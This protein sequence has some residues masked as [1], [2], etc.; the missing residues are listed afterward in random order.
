MF[1]STADD[2]IVNA[3]FS[4]AATKLFPEGVIKKYSEKKLQKKKYS[5]A[6]FMMYLGLK[7]KYDLNHHNIIFADDYRKNVETIF[8]NLPLGDD[9]SFY[10]QNACVTDPSLAPEGGS[11]FYVLVPIANNR[12][13]IDWDG[14]RDIFREKV[15]LCSRE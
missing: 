6:T 13:G 10:I 4:Y 3:D 7:K 9:F 5:C 12:S 8:D 11:T 1:I 15:S 14:Q 2:V